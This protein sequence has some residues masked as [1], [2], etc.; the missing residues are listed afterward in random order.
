MARDTQRRPAS[1]QSSQLLHRDTALVPQSPA[2]CALPA[3]HPLRLVFPD[4]WPARWRA[5]S[6]TN[7]ATRQSRGTS[8]INLSSPRSAI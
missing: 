6:K 8:G 1:P 4:V 7:Q 3:A 2:R 5:L